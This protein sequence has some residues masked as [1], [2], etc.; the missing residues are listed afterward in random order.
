M[1]NVYLR[2]V[3]KFIVGDI[4]RGTP[5][6][7][8]R[9]LKNL[10]IQYQRAW[11]DIADAINRM[12]STNNIPKTTED[13]LYVS[14]NNGNDSYAGT[15]PDRAFATIGAATAAMS[16]GD[17]I[18]VGEGTYDEAVVLD[19]VGVTLFAEPG[20]VIQGNGGTCINITAARCRVMCPGS[21]IVCDPDADQTGVATSSAG[22]FAYISDVRV[23]AD[24][25]AVGTSADLGF[26]IVGN[27]AV[28]EN[29]RCSGPDVAAFKIQGDKVKVSDCC[30]GGNSGYTSI[31]FWATNS[32]DKFRLCGCS[33]SE[34]HESAGLQID[35]GCTN[36]AV[37]SFRS[38]GGD[39][40]WVDNGT[41]GCISDLIFDGADEPYDSYLSS[42]TTFSGAGTTYNIFKLTGS[43]RVIDLHGVV[44]TV[45]PN[46]SSNIHIELYSTN[47]TVDI[48]DDP[49]PDIDSYVVGALL[50]RLAES[51]VGLYGSDPDST[52]A[53]N[54]NTSKFSSKNIVD[55]VKDDAADTYVRAVISNA[56]ASGAIKWQCRWIPLS[57]D[58]FLEAA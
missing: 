40:R 55:C 24:G 16:D 33:Q 47:G 10:A 32:C 5:E 27:G 45:I 53:V 44:T 31:G 51:T 54:E 1:G 28:L 21:S 20:V 22:T 14:A 23:S 25:G 30:T 39:G 56:L 12:N 4:K 18:V 36:Y 34:G 46:T 11:T 48:T 35:S 41:G 7:I 52:P 57:D 13:I 49:G 19:H 42:T 50:S 43:V 38:G 29:C 37:I 15:T 6:E 3:R 2:P 17:M 58:G 9:E 8:E 26:D